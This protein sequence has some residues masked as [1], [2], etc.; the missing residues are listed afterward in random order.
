M[1]V[2]VERNCVMVTV[3]E[4][5]VQGVY[6]YSFYYLLTHSVSH[7]CRSS[8]PSSLSLSSL[9]S[10]SILAAATSPS[11]SASWSFLSLAAY[12][13]ARPTVWW[14]GM[15]RHTS[16]ARASRSPRQAN[17]KVAEWH[18]GEE[19]NNYV[20]YLLMCVDLCVHE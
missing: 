9:S 2:S 5:R 13:M 3:G 20:Q 17:C 10:S 19:Q 16:R 12:L 14:E 18:E 6:L 11:L 7:P 15:R 4:G 1:A 8:P